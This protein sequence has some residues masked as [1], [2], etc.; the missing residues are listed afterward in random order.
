[1]GAADERL[2]VEGF[3]DLQQNLAENSHDI[4]TTANTRQRPERIAPADG[5]TVIGV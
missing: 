3:Q 5:Y 4:A 1:V 2:A